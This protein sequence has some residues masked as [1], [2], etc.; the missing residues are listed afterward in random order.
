[1]GVFVDGVWVVLG[2]RKLKYAILDKSCD[3]IFNGVGIFVI[4]CKSSVKG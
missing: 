3:G 4:Y 2:G 1:M